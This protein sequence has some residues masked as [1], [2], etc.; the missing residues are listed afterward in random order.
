MNTIFETEDRE[1]RQDSEVTLGTGTLLAIFFGLV[2]VC[3]VFFGFGYSMGRHSSEARAAAAQSA[4]TP[5]VTETTAP[6]S[7]RRKPSALEALPSP[8]QEDSTAAD[9]IAPRTVVEQSGNAHSAT[10]EYPAR[11]VAGPSRR[12]ESPAKP[13]RPSPRLIAATSPVAAPRSSSS[14]RSST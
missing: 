12:E 3:G 14:Q 11:S 7:S 13:S 5:A 6:I 9:E 2:V 10:T 8:A 4:A 1:E